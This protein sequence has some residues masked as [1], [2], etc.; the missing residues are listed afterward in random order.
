MARNGGF[1][2][3]DL[4]MKLLGAN[5]ESA[6]DVAYL[7]DYVFDLGIQADEHRVAYEREGRDLLER[8]LYLDLA[9]WG[10]HLFAW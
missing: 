1:Q 10:F 8:G 4:M 2:N 9:E 6:D 3:G 5:P 7:K